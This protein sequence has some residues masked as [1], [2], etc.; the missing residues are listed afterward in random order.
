MFSKANKGMD[1]R[2]FLSKTKL[3]G[4]DNIVIREEFT[5]STMH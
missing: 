5:D 1:C 2:I 3:Q 4:L